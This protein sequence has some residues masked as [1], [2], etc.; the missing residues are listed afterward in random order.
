MV[1]TEKFVFVHLPKTGGTF[2]TE[3]LKR[4]YAGI[5]KK[6]SSFAI[7]L[8]KFLIKANLKNESFFEIESNKIIPFTDRTFGQHDTCNMIPL[9]FQK[10]PK[11]STVRN[12]FDRYVSIYEFRHWERYPLVEKEI[13]KKNFPS[14]PNLTFHEFMEMQ[15]GLFLDKVTGGRKFNIEMG[16]LTWQFILYFFKNPEIVFEK[17][18]ENYFESGDYKIDMYDVHF[19]KTNRLNQGLYELLISFGYNQID[20]EF[21]L[22]EQKVLPLGLG[23]TEDQNWQKYYDDE[24]YK[25]VKFK[26]RLLFKIFPEFLKNE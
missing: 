14:F 4:F 7:K 26:D 5:E 24:L 19:L 13:I 12:P 22:K 23:R 17:L 3:I 20:A 15:N 1:I 9:E 25:A 11:V 16:F 10:L 2:V 6:R 8:N 21:I 18:N